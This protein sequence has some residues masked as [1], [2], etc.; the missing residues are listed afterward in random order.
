MKSIQKQVFAATV[1]FI[2]GASF[3]PV[4]ADHT[5]HEQLAARVQALEAWRD[6]VTIDADDTAIRARKIAAPSNCPAGVDARWEAGF[7]PSITLGCHP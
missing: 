2:I 3:T 6:K 1:A 7:D 5:D 4:S